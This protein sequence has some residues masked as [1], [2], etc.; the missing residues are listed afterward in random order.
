MFVEL[1]VLLYTIHIIHGKINISVPAPPLFK[2]TVWDYAKANKTDI[3][4]SL[5]NIDWESKFKDLSTNDMV[6]HF[7]STI[8]DIVST[9]IPNKVVKF[10]DRDPHGYNTC[11]KNSY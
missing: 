3:L 10:D 8:M 9:F 7:T 11:Y 6:Q 2:R 5:N 4:K 1:I